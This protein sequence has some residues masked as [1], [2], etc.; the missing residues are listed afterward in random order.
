MCWL[1]E[2]LSYRVDVG[3]ETRPSQSFSANPCS[4]PSIKCGRR[5]CAVQ[6]QKVNSAG[7]KIVGHGGVEKLAVEGWVVARRK[8]K[9]YGF[10]TRRRVL[11]V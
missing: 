10:F 3:L 6:M 8:L 4:L 2:D 5:K 11:L 7:E 9:Q 1:V